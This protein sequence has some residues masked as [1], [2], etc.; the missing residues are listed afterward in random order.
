[1]KLV[2]QTLALLRSG[3]FALRGPDPS[4]GRQVIRIAAVLSDV[5]KEGDGVPVALSHQYNG[6]HGKASFTQVSGRRV[7][8][9]VDLLRIEAPR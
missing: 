7:D 5:P 8:L 9:T 2:K 6:G 3:F 1:M 4:A